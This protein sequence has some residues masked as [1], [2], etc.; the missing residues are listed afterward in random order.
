MCENV[1]DD[2]LDKTIKKKNNEVIKKLMIQLRKIINDIDSL[3]INDPD[4]EK[5]L[6]NLNNTFDN[7]NLK[8]NKLK[9]YSRIQNEL[10]DDNNEN[11]DDELLINKE[12]ENLLERQFN[13]IKEQ[14]INASRELRKL[15]PLLHDRIVGS[16]LAGGL[17]HKNIHGGLKLIQKAGNIPELPLEQL[18]TNINRKFNHTT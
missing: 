9:T 7:T 14:R 6:I 10:S 16:P 12:E 13:Q 8:I 5:K 3:N 4:Y 2:L 17:N 11:E 18:L 1:F 15:D